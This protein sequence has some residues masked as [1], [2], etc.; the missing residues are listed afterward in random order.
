MVLSESKQRL[1][2]QHREAEVK[3]AREALGA[4]TDKLNQRQ[5]KRREH[6]AQRIEQALRGN[7]AKRLFDVELDGEDG[8]LRLRYEVNKERLEQEEALDGKYLL[9]TTQGKLSA[10]EMLQR[11]KM[12]DG[13]EKRIGNMKGP[14]QVRPIYV[15]MESR[16]NGLVFLT[17]VALMVFSLLELQM[18]QSIVDTAWRF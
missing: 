1:D 2:Q 11:S 12:R 17:L 4:I 6:V 15:Q 3:K 5:Y 7:K 14:L 18:R 8:A 10:D 16:I 13:V 9:A